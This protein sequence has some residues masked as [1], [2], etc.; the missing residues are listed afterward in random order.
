VKASSEATG[1]RALRYTNIWLAGG[2]LLL[3]FVLAAT[4]APSSGV[5]PNYS[6]KAAH[7]LTFTL[8]MVWFCGVFRL[9]WAG[10]VALSLLAFGILIELLQ[11]TVSYRSAEVADAGFDFLGVLFGWG[12]A[13]AGLASWAVLIERV[14][15]GESS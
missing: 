10:F 5:V 7:F 13:A 8:L 12:L 15:P 14:L 9:R 1:L 4:L 2:I 3:V 11:G 6:D